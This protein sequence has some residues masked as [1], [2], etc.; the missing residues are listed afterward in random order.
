MRGPLPPLL[1]YLRPSMPLPP[2]TMFLWSCL[3]RPRP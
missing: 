3:P 1:L 2:L